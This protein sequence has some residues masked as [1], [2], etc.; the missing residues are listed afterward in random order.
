MRKIFIIAGE[1]SGDLHG[2]NL[3]KALLSAN[4]DLE[5][6]AYG[7][8]KMRQAGASVVR[9]YEEFAFMG[10]FEVLINARK[11]CCAVRMMISRH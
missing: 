11:V 8:P 4:P 6:Q 9:N 2:S 7:G 5:I 1:A 10:F 3:V